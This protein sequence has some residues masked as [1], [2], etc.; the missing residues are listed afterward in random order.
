MVVGLFSLVATD[1]TKVNGL[2]LQQE[3]FILDMRRNF[4]S[5]RAVKHWN[6]ILREAVDLPSLEML[7]SYID[8]GPKDMA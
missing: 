7:K 8:E 4:F 5:K 3:K 2:K 6:R 1:R